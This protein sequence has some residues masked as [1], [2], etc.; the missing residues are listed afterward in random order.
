MNYEAPYRIPS[1]VR[2][3]DPRRGDGLAPLLIGQQNPG[4]VSGVLL[5]VGIRW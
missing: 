4:Q 5:S 1:G 3:A 2:W